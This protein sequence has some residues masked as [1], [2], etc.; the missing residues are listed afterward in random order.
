MWD[1]TIPKNTQLL[2]ICSD[3]VRMLRTSQNYIISSMDSPAFCR[4]SIIWC[5]LWFQL[6]TR[7]SLFGNFDI[8]NR[9]AV[10][11]CRVV[12]KLERPDSR[13]PLWQ[14][15]GSRATL[16]QRS[17]YLTV[18]GPCMDVQMIDRVL[19]FYPRGSAQKYVLI[20]VQLRFPDPQKSQ[21]LAL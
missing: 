8:L 16:L 15:Q 19:S 7:S 5:V 6:L 14:P 11:L 12:R 2:G 4:F 17:T 1:P 13:G 10:P 3:R 20:A 9:Q 18:A 21:V